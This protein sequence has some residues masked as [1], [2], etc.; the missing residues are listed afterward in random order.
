MIGEQKI[1]EKFNFDDVF[2]RDLTVCVLDTLEGKINWVNRFSSGDVN[3]KVPFYYSMSGDERFLL[4]SFQ[5]DVVSNNRFVELNTDMI[6]RGHVTLTSWAPKSDEFANPNVF[7]RMV[8]EN[9]L[10]IKKYLTKVRAIPISAAFNLT[11]LLRTEIDVFK[12]SQ[13]IMDTIWL[14]RY[15]YFEYNFMQIDAIMVVPDSQSIEITREINMTSDNAIKMS[16]DFEV[17]TYYPAYVKNDPNVLVEPK[18]TKWF[19][20]ILRS[21]ESASS[22][23]KTGLPYFTDLKAPEDGNGDSKF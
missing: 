16:L 10:E 17:H 6:P 8:I 1:G 9:K 21:R 20:N 3:V 12:C 4:D 23:T 13:A 7:L 2:L 22:S 18:R 11:I 19:D 14:Y 5:D 15:M